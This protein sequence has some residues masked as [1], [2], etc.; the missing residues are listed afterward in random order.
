MPSKQAKVRPHTRAGKPVRGYTRK[1]T[2]S[3]NIGSVLAGHKKGS[4]PLAVAGAVGIGSL[5]TLFFALHTAWSL[6]EVVIVVA[7]VAGMMLGVKSFL[8]YRRRHPTRYKKPV[9]LS[10]KDRKHYV[11]AKLRMLKPM[12]VYRR[13]VQKFRKNHPMIT[14]A[15]DGWLGKFQVTVTTGKGKTK[16]T[17]SFTVRGAHNATTFASQKKESHRQ[18]G[19]KSPFNISNRQVFR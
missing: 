18:S 7:S 9:T 14:G 2:W 13:R 10:Y 8:G 17:E 12:N 3:E 11:L 19:D 6:A 16:K 4:V 5:T 15:Y 1:Q